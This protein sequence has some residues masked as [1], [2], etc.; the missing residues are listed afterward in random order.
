MSL[1]NLDHRAREDFKVNPSSAFA[2]MLMASYTYYLRYESILSDECFD[3]MAK[4]LL[5]EYDNLEHRYKHLVTKDML[6]AG[7]CYNLRYEDYP[8]GIQRIAESLIREVQ[9]G[10]C[11]SNPC[12]NEA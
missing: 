2:W 3:G 5:K 6:A 12:I 10:I 1:C 8:Y 11:K 4:Y 9:I 7:S